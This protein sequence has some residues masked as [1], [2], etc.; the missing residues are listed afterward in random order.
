MAKRDPKKIL[1]VRNDKLGDFMLSYPAFGLLKASLP[2]SRVYA[3]VPEYTRDMAEACSWIDEVL[4]D[5]YQNKGIQDNL[6]LVRL[7]KQQRF[8]AIISLYSTTRIGFSAFAAGIPYRLAPATK[9]AQ[10][11]Y[12]HRLVQRRSRSEKPEHVYNC[13][14]VLRFCQDHNIPPGNLPLPPLLQFEPEAVHKR[15]HEF[16]QRHQIPAT[17]QLIFVHPGSGG[18]ARN[19]SAEQYAELARQIKSDKG[20]T[21]VISAGPGEYENA[22]HVAALLGDTPHLVYE[23]RAGLKQ[24]AEHIQFAD[25]FIGGS[26]GPVHVAGALDRPTVA[27][28]PRRRSAT[29]LRWQTLNS[30]ARRLAF[31]PPA[32]AEQEDMNKIDVKQVA[33]TISRHFLCQ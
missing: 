13:D 24:F 25:L 3:L 7:F 21:I 9:L 30:P 20:H 17:R 10:F 23:S 4:I 15:H 27:F 16:C 8:D 26:T 19:L 2:D 5:D 6:Q 31:S 1:L 32:D 29:S 22:H 14:L 11:F 28:Y 12:N 18:S 33:D